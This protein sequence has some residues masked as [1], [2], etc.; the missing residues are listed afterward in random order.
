[1]SARRI[2]RTIL[3]LTAL[4]WGAALWATP[5]ISEFMALNSSTLA[6]EDGA[7]SDWIELYNPDPTAVSLA[8]WYLTD[9]ATNKT[10]WQF[11]AVTLSAGG[12]LVVFASD[13]NRRDPAGRLHTNFSLNADGE[14]LALVRPDGITVASEFAPRFPEQSANVSYGYPAGATSGP[15]TFL[16]RPTPGAPNAS[17]RPVTISETVAFSPAAGPFRATFSLALAGAAIGQ[18]IRYVLVTPASGATAPEPTA[19]STLYSGPISITGAAVIR[20]AVFSSSG[21]SKGPTST[22]YFPTLSPALSSFSST[23]PV[24]V[25]DTLGSGPLEKDNVDHVSWLLAF[26]PRTSNAPTFA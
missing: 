17:A 13:K 14:Y 20:A 12:Y 5:T 22:A 18:Q 23:L 6:D 21:E 3:S 25:L 24:F 26:P 8:G 9:N 2:Q 1:M 10:K 16:S 7:F 11:P 4:A 19:T 15:A